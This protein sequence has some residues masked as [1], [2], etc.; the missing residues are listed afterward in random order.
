MEL[1]IALFLDSIGTKWD[2]EIKR[3]PYMNHITGKRSYY[4]IDFI[5]DKEWIEVKPAESMIPS[6]KRLYASAAAKQAGAIFR[7]CTD[8]ERSKGWEL[9]LNGYRSSEYSFI[10]QTPSKS[11]KQISYYFKTQRDLELFKYPNGF[12]YHYRSCVAPTI[13]KLVLR[14]I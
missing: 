8:I 3:V 5:T 9:L 13:F 10:H 2:Y 4:L 14:R 11:C 6:D 1:T 12:K 7:G